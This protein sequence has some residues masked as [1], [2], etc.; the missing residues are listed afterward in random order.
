MLGELNSAEAD[1]GLGVESGFLVNLSP[2]RP[3]TV[4]MAA[5]EALGGEEKE[6]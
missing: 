5:K 1:D 6:T 4:A 2:S 3:E